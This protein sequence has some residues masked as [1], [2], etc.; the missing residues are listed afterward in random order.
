MA[1]KEARARIRINQLLAEAQW[2]F[3]DDASGPANIALEPNVKI[4]TSQV[5]GLGA[6]FEKTKNG[7]VDFLLLDARGKPLIILEAKAEDKNPL[8]GKEQARKYARSQNCRFV[9]LSNG[10]LH[11]FW[12]LERGNPYIITSFPTPDS[13]IGYHK[14]TPHPQRLYEEPVKDDFIVLT[15]RPAYRDEAAWK[16]AA[17]RK[18]FVEKNSLRFLRPYPQSLSPR[19]IRQ[20]SGQ[21]LYAMRHSLLTPIII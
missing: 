6:D 2:R 5:D 4:T 11:Y 7:F 16:N 15:Q 1:A 19:L 17:E 3:F 12:D 20:P 18:G 10:N 9:I 13:V 21:V 8:N 14:V